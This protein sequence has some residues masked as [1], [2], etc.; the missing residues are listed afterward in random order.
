[1][2]KLQGARA[3]HC[4]EKCLWSQLCCEIFENENEHSSRGVSLQLPSIPLQHG[5]SRLERPLENITQVA[6]RE[7]NK[8]FLCGPAKKGVIVAGL[9][10]WDVRHST[11]FE[12]EGA[13]RKIVFWGIVN[14]DR[15]G[16]RPFHRRASGAV[17]TPSNHIHA[18]A[19]CAR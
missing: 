5:I 14:G 9:G 4:V 3:R 10:L 17:S 11:I 8:A 6:L 19:G 18:D 16:H 12:G 2:R 1:M 15:E 7:I 13:A